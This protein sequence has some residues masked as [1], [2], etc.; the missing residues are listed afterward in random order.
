MALS[1]LRCVRASSLCLVLPSR[2]GSSLCAAP[3]APSLAR[4]PLL[5]LPLSRSYFRRP[6]PSLTAADVETLFRSRRLRDRARVSPGQRSESDMHATGEARRSGFLWSRHDCGQAASDTHFQLCCNIRVPYV[7]A[8]RDGTELVVDV[9]PARSSAA[10]GPAAAAADAAARRALLT[11]FQA[12]ISASP[13]AQVSA[14]RVSSDASGAALPLALSERTASE[15]PAPAELGT[16]GKEGLSE[17]FL[18]LSRGRAEGLQLAGELVETYRRVLRLPSKAD[19]AATAADRLAAR[20]A[21]EDALKVRRLTRLVEDPKAV[22]EL[23]VKA[24]AVDGFV[25]ALE[26]GVASTVPPR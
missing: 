14:L 12:V 13:G 17:A 25:A 1:P 4:H 7:A 10:R 6:L 26:A 19:R 8:G 22:R 2:V 3:S 23:R 18:V 21:R 16:V 11:A 15:A 24:G 20:A 5:S 9:R